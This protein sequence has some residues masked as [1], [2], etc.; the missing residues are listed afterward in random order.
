MALAVVWLSRNSGRSTIPQN[1]ASLRFNFYKGRMIFFVYLF[2]DG[3]HLYFLW[4]AD[5]PSLYHFQGRPIFFLLMGVTYIQLFTNDL[6]IPW[7]CR[8]FLNLHS[9]YEF[10]KHLII[11]VLSQASSLANIEVNIGLSLTVSCIC[12]SIVSELN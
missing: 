2:I 8:E 10:S 11:I 7:G 3:F 5:C 4:I 6:N 12:L 1:F 9:L